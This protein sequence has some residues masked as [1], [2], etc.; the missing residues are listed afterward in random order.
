MELP[1]M[2]WH[3]IKHP[4]TMSPR[5]F[6]VCS[7]I[8]QVSLD[9]LG[10]WLGVMYGINSKRKKSRKQPCLCGGIAQSI[11]VKKTHTGYTKQVTD[12]IQQFIYGLYSTLNWSMRKSKCVFRNK[13]KTNNDLWKVSACEY[14]IIWM[15][16]LI[17]SKICQCYTNEK[18]KNFCFKILSSLYD[19]F[20]SSFLKKNE[21]FGTSL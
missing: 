12:A 11:V 15:I 19:K 5:T 21:L 2:C 13:T 3:N 10:G 6:E 20:V 18:S 1:F 16:N 4:I 17:F 9:I 14:L 8:E 7:P